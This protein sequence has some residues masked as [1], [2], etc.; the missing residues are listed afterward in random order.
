MNNDNSSVG[1]VDAIEWA[2]ILCGHHIQNDWASRATNAL[3]ILCETWT[4]PQ[5]NYLDDSEGSN[6]AQLLIGSFILT[7]RPLMHHVSRR[8]FGDTSNHPGD[9]A[10]LKPHYSP[11]LV[12]CDFCLF[13][14]LK[15]PL[16]GK[17]FQTISEVQENMIGQLMVTGR[18]VCSPKVPSLKGTEASLSYVQ[19][20]LY[21]IFLNKCLYFSYYMARCLLDRPCICLI[22]PL[23]FCF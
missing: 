3:H 8:V 21:H 10:P 2:C 6:Y 14:K 16:Q 18:T 1:A 23:F 4:F 15:S 7:T 13:P 12:P 17:R 9:S 19:C 5:G 22:C 11:D 20:F